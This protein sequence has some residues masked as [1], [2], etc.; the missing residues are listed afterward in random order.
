MTLYEKTQQAKFNMRTALK[1]G[2]TV[3]NLSVKTAKDTYGLGIAY[4]T[5]QEDVGFSVHQ[6]TLR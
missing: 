4:L 2:K 5:F 1:T 3:K 6:K